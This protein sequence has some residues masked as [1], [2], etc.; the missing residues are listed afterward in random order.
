MASL[1]EFLALNYPSRIWDSGAPPAPP[2]HAV[3]A[4][5]LTLGAMA[6]EGRGRGV[7]SRR[8]SSKQSNYE[9]SHLI[10]H[11][12]SSSGRQPQ[13]NRGFRPRLEFSSAS[14]RLPRDPRDPRLPLEPRV[15]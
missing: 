11:A 14:E 12:A 15:L 5:E 9:S 13:R 4:S 7:R 10:F 1:P 3:V 8:G 6:H 2:S